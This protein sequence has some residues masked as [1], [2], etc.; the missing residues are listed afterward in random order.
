VLYVLIHKIS[1]IAG[2]NWLWKR[3]F[4]ENPRRPKIFCG[5]KGRFL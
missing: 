1:P 5:N 2:N 3:K 4:P